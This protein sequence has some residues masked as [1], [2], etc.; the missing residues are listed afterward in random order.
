[1]IEFAGDNVSDPDVIIV[2]APSNINR[3]QVVV[4]PG[5]NGAPTGSSTSGSAQE[6]RRSSGRDSRRTVPQH[7]K[8]RPLLM[9]VRLL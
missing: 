9:A 7:A 8:V 6:P 1:V 3:P 5:S 2:H 4:V